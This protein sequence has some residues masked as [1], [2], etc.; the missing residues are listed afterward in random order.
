M[1]LFRH[2]YFVHILWWTGLYFFWVMV[3]QKR[4]FAFSQTATIEFCYLLF[5]S[6]NFYFNILL[7]IPIFLYKQRYVEYALL[8][9]LAVFITSVLR[10]PLALFMNAN[11]F[12]IG[13]PQPTASALLVAS[14]LNIFI[15]SA[16]IVSVKIVLDRFRVQQYVEEIKK[17]KSKTELD[18][19]NAQLNP[20]FL[21]N[22]I[23]S[24]YGHIDKDNSTARNMLLTFSDMLRYQLYDCNN[25][26]ID[27]NRELEYIKNYVSLQRS[28]KEEDLIVN[29]HVD[30]NV[31][32]IKVAPLLFICFVENAFKYVG[33]TEEGENRIDISFSR[34]GNALLFK[35]LNTKD[36]I[37]VTN[38]EH[39]GIGIGNTRRRLDL[40][41]REHHFLDIQE[42]KEYYLV[43]LKIEPDAVE[44][45][46]SG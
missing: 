33:V 8:F 26:A 37:P 1:K 28:R 10:V 9:L 5:I 3:F 45:H 22:S 11:I 7:A 15:W 20:H 35:C 40:H 36:P 46:Y 27:I 41:Y 31:K 44:M 21:F 29:F 32:G 18:F 2:K 39:K 24:I 16:L 42:N 30:R 4:S 25:E 38:I 6:A 13:K 14:F 12:L 17:E 43:K 23:N 34:Q 19:L